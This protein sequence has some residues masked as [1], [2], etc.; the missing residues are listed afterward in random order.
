VLL[1]LLKLYS[2][3]LHHCTPAPITA[4]LDTLYSYTFLN[5]PKFADKYRKKKDKYSSCCLSCTCGHFTAV[6]DPAGTCP[7]AR[8]KKLAENLEKY[9]CNLLGEIC[10]FSTFSTVLEPFWHLYIPR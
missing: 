8:N 10:T 6:I 4:V 9:S 3:A 7:F 5:N 1:L 2:C